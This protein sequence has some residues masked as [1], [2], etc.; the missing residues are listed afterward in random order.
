[1]RAAGPSERCAGIPGGNTQDIQGRSG[2]DVL[3]AC[4]A[5]ADVASPA[6]AGAADGLGMRCFDAGARGIVLAELVGEL[7]TPRGLERLEVLARLQADDARLQ[8]G[9]GAA[10]AERTGRAILAGKACFPGHASLWV[11]VG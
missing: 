5:K 3:N 9:P 6:Y 4:L 11:G 7:P 2:G 10:R 1:M 8:L